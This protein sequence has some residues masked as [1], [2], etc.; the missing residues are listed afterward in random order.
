M[1]IRRNG[2]LEGCQS[3]RIVQET[4]FRTRCLTDGSGIFT[5]GLF[6][7]RLPEL[8]RHSR[9][10]IPSLRRGNQRQRQAMRMSASRS[11]SVRVPA[12]NCH[13]MGWTTEVSGLSLKDWRVCYAEHNRNEQVLLHQKLYGHALQVQQDIGSYTSSVTQRTGTR[14]SLYS[15]VKEPK[16][17]PSFLVRQDLFQP[18]RETFCAGLSVHEDCSRR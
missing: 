8:R 10:K 14:R 7:S 9:L 18:L 12:W 16:A 3:R 2:C 5:R 6:P 17:G 4:M 13:E 15:D 1:I 11:S